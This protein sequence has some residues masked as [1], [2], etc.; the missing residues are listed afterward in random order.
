M[1]RIRDKATSASL[2]LA[3]LATPA[4]AA[5][6]SATGGYDYYQ[7]PVSFTRGV[8]AAV[9]ASVPR[10]SAALAGVRYD[11]QQTGLGT[12]AIVTG[13][14]QVHPLLAVLA[15]GTRFF[16]DEGFR[17][18]R[19][20]L[21]P[22]LS[23][24][25]ATTQLSYVRD[26]EDAGATTQTG[27]IESEFPLIE[28]LKGRANASYASAGAGVHGA[29][30]AVGLGW[31]PFAR[32]ELAGEVGLAQQAAASANQPGPRGLLSPILG[33]KNKTQTTSETSFS[34][35]ALVSVRIS[36]P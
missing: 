7:G 22:R 25:S 8:V 6:L 31:S 26:Q 34:P 33:P 21:G 14:V 27:M 17:S 29:Q 10:A 23:L 18:W 30:A 9:G 20:K 36:A 5:T 19:L 3:I 32:L 16:G 35:T 15:Q 13:A 2:L 1:L 12:S 4:A 11:D 24:G 28:S